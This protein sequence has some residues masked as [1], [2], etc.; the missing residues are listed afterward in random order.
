MDLQKFVTENYPEL[1]EWLN[2]AMIGYAGAD[3][4]SLPAEEVAAD[5]LSRA[6]VKADLFEGDEVAARSWLFTLA[7]NLLVTRL[8]QRRRRRFVERISFDAHTSVYDIPDPHAGS[9][10]DAM[11]L[12][13][14]AALAQASI[15]QLRE[16][17]AV[18][19]LLHA[20]ENRSIPEIAEFLGV[21][22]DVVRQRICRGRRALADL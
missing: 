16:S 11:L 12:R 18:P 19:L 21:S 7:R 9:Q 2:R 22:R 1:Q 5:A 4:A 6:C 3:A 14:E 15:R 17:Y 20:L 8:R 10:L 13:E